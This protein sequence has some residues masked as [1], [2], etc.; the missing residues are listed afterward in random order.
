MVS[1][2]ELFLPTL[3]ILEAAVTAAYTNLAIFMVNFREFCFCSLHM[4]ASTNND[5]D[6]IMIL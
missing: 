6:T 5:E 4:T 3:L 1:R 2:E